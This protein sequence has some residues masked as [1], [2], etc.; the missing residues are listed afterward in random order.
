MQRFTRI[1]LPYAVSGFLA[2]ACYVALQPQVLPDTAIDFNEMW[3][4]PLR[5]STIVQFFLLAGTPSANT[6]N[7]VAWSLVYE[8]RISLLLPLLYVLALRLPWSLWLFVIAELIANRFRQQTVPFHGADFASGLDVTVHF[9]LPF[10][11]GTFLAV[12]Y[13]RG[14]FRVST[15]RLRRPRCCSSWL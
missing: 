3:S 10:V 11:L 9:V 14:Q 6:I 12:G 4:E 2:I 8:L 7:T 1:Y 13:G 5:N 15:P